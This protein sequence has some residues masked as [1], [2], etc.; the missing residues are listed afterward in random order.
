MNMGVRACGVL[1]VMVLGATAYRA[2]YGAEPPVRFTR[3]PTAVRT[4]EGKV[5]I[6]FAVSRETDVAVSVLDSRGR[7]IRHLAAG[8]LGGTAPAP[9]QKGTLSQELTWDGRDDGGRP[10]GN[11]PFTVR[12]AVGLTPVLDGMIGW[13]PAW[14][15]S[16]RA[17]AVGPGGEL[18]VFHVFGGLHPGDG[19]MACSVFSREGKYLREILPYPADLPDE[20]VRG[21]KR[22]EL[23][24][25]K[26]I[27]FIYQAETR[28][29]VPGAGD[30]QEHQ[31]VVTRDGRVGFVGRME[32]LRYSR[33]GPLHLIVIHADGSVPPDGV[34]RTL[35][36][37]RAMSATL[38]LSPDEK[39][40]YASDVRKSKG[41]YGIPVNV[42]YKFGWNDKK[43]VPFLGGKDAAGK[44]ALNDPKGIVTD[45]D[46]N[47]WVADKGNNRVAVF[48]PDGSFVAELPCPRPERVAVHPK[49]RA[50]YVLGGERINTLWKYASLKNPAPVAR[51]TLPCFRHRGYRV[52]MV[53][54]AGAD[55]PVLWFAS[56]KGYYAHFTLLRVKD[57][58]EAFGK[59]VDVA[60]LN[61]RPCAG[62]VTTLTVDREGE[63]VYVG[64]GPRFDGP[65]GEMENVRLRIARGSYREGAV[66]SIGLDGFIYLHSSG[67][68]RGVYRFDRSLKPAPFAG[69]T[70]NY[71]PN[72]GS[73]RLRARGL[74]A[75]HRGY[76]YLLWQK[77]KNKQSPGD[78]PDANALA[79]YAPDGKL[80]KEK[81]V[82]SEMRSINSVRV[83]Y[84][85]NIIF[86]L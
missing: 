10:A 70:S 16:V 53:L 72:P 34:V 78:H 51:A 44:S 61:K 15:G 47:L 58:G 68:K 4:G 80:V 22:I 6:S 84:R 26:K 23:D 19:S 1:V 85:G 31:A 73:L 60:K 75:D 67:K 48:R 37:P 63:K 7:V 20:K 30:L 43:A 21:L 2:G 59:P 14:L 13:N 25:G 49:T 18:F 69:T 32:Y 8:M 74:T 40:I 64:R 56:G 52:V 42:I 28:S 17:L 41:H 77:P 79:L 12:V 3:E 66:M 71:I 76:L 45:T 55:P 5:K 86:V 62:P 54:D 35:I 11:G 27:P 38:T 82:D 81:L 36:H 33:E 9:L 57:R 83:D 24:D 50:I 39:T 29:L 65:T 46:G